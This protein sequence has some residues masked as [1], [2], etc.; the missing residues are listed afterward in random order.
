MGL[1]NFRILTRK[2]YDKGMTEKQEEVIYKEEKK[3][4]YMQE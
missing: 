3:Q 1:D 2:K 4:I